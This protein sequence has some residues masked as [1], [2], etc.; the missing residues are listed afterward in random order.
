MQYKYGLIGEKLGHSFSP[1]IHAEFGNSEYTL[2]PLKPEQVKEFIYNTS[3]Q[4]VNVTIP[5]KQ[6]VM[7]YCDYISE[8]A[9][10]IGC[11]NTLVREQDGTISGYNTDV[12]GMEQLIHHAQ[13]CVEGKK[14][15]ILGGGGTSLTARYVAA[16]MKA[17][18]VVF[19]SRQGPVYYHQ[20]NAHTDTQVIIDTTSVGMYPNNDGVAIDLNMFPICEGVVDVVYNP[21]ASDL[22]L[23]AKKRGIPCAGGLYMLIAQ[24]WKAAELFAGQQIR[25][26]Q[27]RKVYDT[28]AIHMRNIVLIGMPGSGKSVIGHE[29]AVRL[30]KTFVDTDKLVEQKAGKSIPEIFREN[31]ELYFRELEKETIAEVAKCSGQIIAT[32]GGAILKEESVRRLKQ[33]GTLYFIERDIH[34]L[35][36]KGRPL[37]VSQRTLSKL[38]E[39]RLPIY[40]QVADKRMEN[41]TSIDEVVGKIGEDFYK[42]VGD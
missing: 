8:E 35:D 36:T 2:I 5:Y 7:E 14:V 21:H 31:G 25:K 33:N 6:T 29:L 23:E 22:I 18:E 34:D 1:M 11:V 30:N 26:E 39:E 37:S 24:A 28:V 15:L 16:K 20:L 12:Y 10:V 32:G 4:G 40:T 19:V 42:H 41:N 27:A 13:I 38:Y 17:R 9:R 3:F